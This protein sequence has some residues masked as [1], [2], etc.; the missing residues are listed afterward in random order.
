MSPAVDNE[1]ADHVDADVAS[2]AASARA[3]VLRL[4]ARKPLHVGSALSV[5][6]LLAVLYTTVL[7]RR[8]DDPWWSGRDRLVLSKGHGAYGLYAVLAELGVL[9][10]CLDGLPGHPSDGI[11]GVEAATG[12]LGHGLSIGCGMA[13]GLRRAGRDQR[14]FVVTG[15]GELDEGS[16]WEAAQFAAHHQLDNLVAVVDRNGLQQEGRTEQVLGLEPLADKWRAFGWAVS[17]VNGHDPAAVRT[18]VTGLI[19]RR[20]PGV[21]IAD[22]VKGKGVSF[23]EGQPSWHMGQLTEEQLDAALAELF[24]GQE[25]SLS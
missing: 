23:M 1:S 11:P 13:L 5:I 10:D 8:P 4:A 14:V 12:A 19:D 21:L 7:R 24:A 9:D 3:R 18:A 22:T 2:F 25:A 16:N 20:G 15:D 6:D 17:V